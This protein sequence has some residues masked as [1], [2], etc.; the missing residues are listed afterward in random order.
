[1]TV[2]RYLALSPVRARSVD[3]AENRRWPGIATMPAI[4]VPRR[5]FLWKTFCRFLLYR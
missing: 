3:R 4:G 5:R 2:A 1:M